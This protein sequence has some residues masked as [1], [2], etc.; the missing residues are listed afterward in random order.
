MTDEF[1]QRLQAG[2]EDAYEVF[3]NE[4]APIWISFFTSQKRPYRL[5]RDEAEDVVQETMM[6]IFLKISTYDLAGPA[7]LSTW[8]FTI[9]IRKAIGVY[10]EK[11][12]LTPITDL[13]KAELKS[14]RSLEERFE[15]QL[16]LES[17]IRGDGRLQRTLRSLKEKERRVVLLKVVEGLTHAEIAHKLGMSQAA[18]RVLF[19]RAKSKL[20][21]RL[22]GALRNTDEPRRIR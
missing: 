22:E 5:T 13:D 19:H 11:A 17:W 2:E 15:Q 7:S 18:V 12:K 10:R 3:Y 20:K 8:F 14:D 16:S 21:L 4:F 1:L 6:T 9:A